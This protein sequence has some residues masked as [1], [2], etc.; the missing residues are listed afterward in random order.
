MNAACKA[1]GERVA[2]MAIGEM[3][4]NEKTNEGRL[5]LERPGQLGGRPDRLT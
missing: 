1:T 3:T 2:A 4:N 5:E